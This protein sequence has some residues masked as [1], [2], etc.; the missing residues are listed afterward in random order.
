LRALR[1]LGYGILTG[2]GSGVATAL[3]IA[4]IVAFVSTHDGDVAGS[5]I[6][7]LFIAFYGSLI[8]GAVGAIVG[9]TLGLGLGA[10]RCER[11]ARWITPGLLVLLFLL[12]LALM[13]EPTTQTRSDQVTLSILL[14]IGPLGLIGF[15]AGIAFEKMIDHSESKPAG[16]CSGME[17]GL[18]RS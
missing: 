13:A 12:L 2:I 6:V 5:A 18:V 3:A 9:A 1:G 15:V 10:I 16:E 8:G 7:A 11:H 4:L 14:Y 17:K